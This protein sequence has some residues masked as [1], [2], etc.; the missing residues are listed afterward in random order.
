MFSYLFPVC[1]PYRGP[2]LPGSPVLLQSNLYHFSGLEWMMSGTRDCRIR[3]EAQSF[4]HVLS[5]SGTRD[6]RIRG[7]TQS[8]THVLSFFTF[9]LLPAVPQGS[10]LAGPILQVWKLRLREFTL[11]SSQGYVASSSKARD[12]SILATMICCLIHRQ[13]FNP[14]VPAW[15]LLAICHSTSLWAEGSWEKGHYGALQ[16]WEAQ[17]LNLYPLPKALTLLCCLP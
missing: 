12:H 9:P 13:N 17:M 3:G 14:P 11:I 10:T 7:E 15:P 16:V 4:T 1:K 5:F 2:D 8:S 6:C